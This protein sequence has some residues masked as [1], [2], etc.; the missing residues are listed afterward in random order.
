L[1]LAAVQIPSPWEVLDLSPAEK[2]V[3]G[4]AELAMLAAAPGGV[5]RLAEPRV[6]RAAVRLAPEGSAVA[7]ADYLTSLRAQ[8]RTDDR[9]RCDL[10]A[11]MDDVSEARL[12]AVLA[13][14]CVESGLV[15]DVRGRS[16]SVLRRLDALLDLAHVPFAAADVQA[17]YDELAAE[18]LDARTSS[19]DGPGARYRATGLGWFGRTST[20]GRLRPAGPVDADAAACAR[21]LNTVLAALDCAQPSLPD[22]SAVAD[23]LAVPAAAAA[24]R[25]RLQDRRLPLAEIAEAWGQSNM[26]AWAV[27]FV[28]EALEATPAAEAAIPRPRAAQA[29][30]R[31]LRAI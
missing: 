26:L 10:A 15:R 4:L 21:L 2:L 18:L 23:A 16:G 12:R 7:V 20:L 19:A 6:Q 22:A 30:Q 29:E 27:G 13:D 17:G 3:G 5:E 1:Q 31:R 11:A 28:D 25:V 9:W 8:A 14:L 24:E